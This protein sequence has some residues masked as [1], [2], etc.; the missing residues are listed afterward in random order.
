MAN[1]NTDL[2]T[3]ISDITKNEYKATCP[4]TDCEFK[5]HVIRCGYPCSKCKYLVKSNYYVAEK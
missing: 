3:R 5:E 1:L 2:Q 4:Q